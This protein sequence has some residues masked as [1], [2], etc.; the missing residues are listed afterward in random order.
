MISPGVVNVPE[1]VAPV[2]VPRLAVTANVRSVTGSWSS[3]T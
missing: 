3:V 2:K 1:K